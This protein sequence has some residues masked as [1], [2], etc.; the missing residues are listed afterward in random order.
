[1][2]VYYPQR[3]HVFITPNERRALTGKY[4]ITP[5]GNGFRLESVIIVDTR[6]GEVARVPTI[7]LAHKLVDALNDKEHRKL[8]LAYIKKGDWSKDL[9]IPR[10]KGENIRPTRRKQVTKNKSSAAVALPPVLK[11]KK[12]VMWS[13]PTP[14]RIEKMTIIR[15]MPR[16]REFDAAAEPYNLEDMK[17]ALDTAY[18]GGNINTFNQKVANRIER[19]KYARKAGRYP[20]SGWWTR[21]GKDE[22]LDDLANELEEDYLAEQ[23]ESNLRTGGP[24]RQSNRN[25][26]LDALAKQLEDDLDL[27]DLDDIVADID[28]Y[29][30]M[31]LFRDGM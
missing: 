29:L 2:Y 18:L 5:E 15:E 17:E 28:D 14:E 23:F 30:A 13:A 7:L 25:A 6:G 26:E 10:V 19:I 3:E 8:A 16:Q 24:A 12:R 20:K 31:G 11:K 21:D 22:M 4:V 9:Y 1:M 27:D